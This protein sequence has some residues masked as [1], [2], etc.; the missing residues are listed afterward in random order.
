MR[1]LRFSLL[2]ATVAVLFAGL[3]LGLNMC[4]QRTNDGP[5]EQRDYG[6]PVPFFSEWGPRTPDSFTVAASGFYPLSMG[7]DLLV[8]AS[9]ILIILLTPLHRLVPSRWMSAGRDPRP[10]DGPST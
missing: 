10:D 5:A 7:V 9:G 6:W 1:S 8:G 3:M 4:P 2:S